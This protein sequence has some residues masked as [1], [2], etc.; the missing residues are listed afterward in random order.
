MAEKKLIRPTIENL[1]RHGAMP[2]TRWLIA[3][4]KERAVITYG[5]AKRRLENE[6]GFST[7]FSTMMGRPAGSAMDNILAIDPDAPLINV[8]LVQQ[9]DRIPGDGAGSYMARRFGNPI[10]GEKDARKRHPELWRQFFERA[11]TE[12]YAYPDWEA[13]YERVYNR[14]FQPDPEA[15]RR[16]NNRDG[17]ERDGLPRGRRGEGD[18]HKAL[19]LWV[20]RNPKQVLPK[21]A[22]VRTDT[23]V[24]LLSGDQV[25]SVYYGATS[26]VAIEVKSRDSNEAD[27]R[28][29]VFQCVK[30]RA[31]LQ[32]MDA[33]EAA[34]VQALL[35]TE[36]PLLSDLAKLARRL[37][38]RHIVVPQNRRG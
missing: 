9:G 17:T 29:G 30:Y 32:A 34:P 27:L 3:A 35:A 36:T 23:E 37:K 1:T 19:R 10:L 24:E 5:E 18:H 8:L 38:I 21:R 20:T 2:L 14:A 15:V 7:I 28:R 11:A 22:V 33:R 16:R 13:L 25:D 4:A 26:T 6:Q 31:V 12:V